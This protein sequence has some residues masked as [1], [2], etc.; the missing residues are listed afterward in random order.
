M[1][2]SAVNSKKVHFELDG[3]M[4]SSTNT[5]PHLFTDK[6]VFDCLKSIHRISFVNKELNKND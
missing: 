2:M 1:I 5:N 4:V 6:Y 3:V